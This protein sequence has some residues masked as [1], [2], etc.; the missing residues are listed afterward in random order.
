[1][2]RRCRT[3]PGA[4]YPEHALISPPPTPAMQDPVPLYATAHA[5]DRHF[6]QGLL[7]ELD[8]RATEVLLPVEAPYI[9]IDRH[10]AHLFF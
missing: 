2:T 7:R 4:N 10:G 8:R 9:P 6:D 3:A 5:S 1:M